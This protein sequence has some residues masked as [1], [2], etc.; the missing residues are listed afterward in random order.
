MFYDTPRCVQQSR[1]IRSCSFGNGLENGNKEYAAEGTIRNENECMLAHKKWCEFKLKSLYDANSMFAGEIQGVFV[2]PYT[3]MT[4]DM[5]E[6][7]GRFHG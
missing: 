5:D 7:L 1:A 2:L 6:N 3:K 4:L